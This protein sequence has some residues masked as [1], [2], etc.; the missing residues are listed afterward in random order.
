MLYKQ[1]VIFLEL[2][3]I[4]SICEC[5]R[6]RIASLGR[7]WRVVRHWSEESLCSLHRLFLLGSRIHSDQILCGH[8]S[9]LAYVHCVLYLCRLF[10]DIWNIRYSTSPRNE[11]KDVRWNSEDSERTIQISNSTLKLSDILQNHA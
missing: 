5:C 9:S 7:C 2:I 4:R 8:S 11:R 10:R 6:F 1:I 3:C